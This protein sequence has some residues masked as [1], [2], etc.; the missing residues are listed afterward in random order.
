MIRNLCISN[1]LIK[2]SLF[3]A[4]FIFFVI[5]VA[6][7]IP[8]IHNS[9]PESQ[10]VEQN[11]LP[12]ANQ[13]EINSAETS[14][15]NNPHINFYVEK[16]TGIAHLTVR[17]ASIQSTLEKITK[18]RN[19]ILVIS[20]DAEQP[21]QQILNIRINIHIEN[22]LYKLL[23]N[24]PHKII[25]L[26]DNDP[27]NKKIFYCI[28]K[29]ACSDMQSLL[30]FDYT[31]QQDPYDSVIP[32]DTFQKAMAMEIS[33][34]TAID[35]SSNKFS[36]LSKKSEILKAEFRYASSSTKITI[37]NTLDANLDVEFFI[38]ALNHEQ[39]TMVRQTAARELFL[40]KNN[41][42]T[43]ALVNSLDDADEILVITILNFIKDSNDMELR[44][45]AFSLVA[46]HPSK[47]IKHSLK[48]FELKES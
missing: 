28:G 48:S 4:A 46:N 41:Y 47:A 36:E 12:Y 8:V 31:N 30:Q 34:D 5:L 2:K 32:S 38:D 7:T 39:N 23:I 13:A 17:S 18:D 43:N 20:P 37:L 25:K 24:I 45:R 44:Y 40:L 3:I 42:A 22:I 9:A 19:I 35:S 11:F 16:S 21:L 1:T 26:A 6:T 33:P 29:T 15:K 27:G 14:I 10:L